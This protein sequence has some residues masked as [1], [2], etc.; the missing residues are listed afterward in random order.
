MFNVFGGGQHQN[1][2]WLVPVLVLTVVFL[3]L[4]LVRRHR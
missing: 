4:G 2:G 3:R 1:V